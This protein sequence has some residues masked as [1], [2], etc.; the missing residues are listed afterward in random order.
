[1]IHKQFTVNNYQ[2]GYLIIYC[3]IVYFLLFFVSYNIV[4]T[5]KS[6]EFNVLKSLCFKA[7]FI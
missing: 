3:L 4:I 1:M 6:L 7:A 5:I 2:V